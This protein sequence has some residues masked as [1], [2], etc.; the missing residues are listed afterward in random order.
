MLLRDIFRRRDAELRSYFL[1]NKAAFRKERLFYVIQAGRLQCLNG[2]YLTE[3]STDLARLLLDRS[4]DMPQHSQSVVREVST[5]ERLLE[6]LTRVG[7]RK[8]SDL[9]RKTTEH[10]AAFLTVM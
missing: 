2:A 4:E 1:G 5:G 10:S 8:F 3:V 6:L 7:Q 9:V